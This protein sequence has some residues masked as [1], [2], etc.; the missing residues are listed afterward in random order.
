MILS[1]TEPVH[2]KS[3]WISDIHLGSI[4][5]KQDHLYDFLTNISCENL[6]LNGDIIDKWLLQ[7]TND[8]HITLQKFNRILS[9]IKNKGTK[10]TFL[11]GNH[12]GLIDLKLYFPTFSYENE[13]IYQTVSNKKYLIFHGDKLDRSVNLRKNF[14]P[15]IGTYI[16]E[17]SL[18]K[19]KKNKSGKFARR[20]KVF[21]K[22]FFYFVFRYYSGLYKYLKVNNFD[23]VICGH[24]HQPKISKIN[25]K[26]Y[27]NSGDWI[28]NCTFL[29]ETES[30]D[31]KLFRWELSNS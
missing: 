5:T 7:N 11:N 8:Y 1:I 21:T 29:L 16:Y 4:G 10:I 14:L 15:K 18:K 6:Y 31:F 26:D 9:E 20:L 24:S 12:D 2:A 17:Y 22:N 19:S 3:I 25:T 23:G 27:L 30:G 13:I 28:D